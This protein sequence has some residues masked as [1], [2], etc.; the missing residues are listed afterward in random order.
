MTKDEIRDEALQ[1]IDG[2]E[3]CTVV[4]AT[5]VGKTLLGLTHMN[6]NSTDLMKCL[7][8]GPKLTVYDTWMSQ[9]DEHNMSHL[10]SR[11]KFSTYLSL[12]KLNPD[13][14]DII[15]FDE[16]HNL[17][18]KHLLFLS[19]FKGKIL[20]LTGT[21]PKRENSEKG[22]IIKQYAPI[23]YTYLI[24]DA[25]GDKILNDYHIFVHYLDLGKDKTVKVK[26]RSGYFYTSEIQN[27]NYWSK[28]CFLEVSHMIKIMRMKAMM[29]YP[30]K[31]KYAKLLANSI[32]EKCI[33]FANTKE[34]AEEICRHSYHSTN[35]ESKENLEKFRKGEIKKLS[36]VLQL[37]EGVN[38]PDLEQGII[39]HSYAN[40]HKS[41]QRIG[42]L[43]RLNPD[44]KCIIH[45]LCYKDTVDE[46]WVKS[47][48]E[49][50]DR[51]KITYGYF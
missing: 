51:E 29:S 6:K 9:A 30:S 16:I 7:V 10:K 23:S 49:T 27:Y 21:P 20:G 24:N 13:D 35:S 50:F 31:V 12:T 46:D 38:I 5:G 45:I 26:T 1:T 41:S 42:R 47:A 36:S 8:V 22:R 34:Q 3:R 32:K 19:L 18:P 28:R 25:V 15:Y 11:I 40:E 37:S 14:Y 17:L 4:L 33:V 39:L 43:M 48:L 2:K 44:Q